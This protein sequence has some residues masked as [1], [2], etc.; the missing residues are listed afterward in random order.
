MDVSRLRVG[1]EDFLVS[2]MI[3]RCPKS[4]M[5]RELTKNAIEAASCADAG[6]RLVEFSPL[7]VNGVRKLAIWN[8]GPGMNADEL[9]QICDI[10]SSIGKQNALDQNF[11]MGAKVAS[12][13]SNTVG[14]RYRSCKNAK[15]HQVIMGKID[16]V[17]GRLRQVGS[18]GGEAVVLDVTGQAVA[19][20]RTLAYDWTEVVLLGND[21]SQDTVTDPYHGNPAMPAHWIA[22]E[23]YTRFFILPP[24]VSIILK[25]GCNI[26]GGD[27]EFAAMAARL[28]QFTK[29]EAVRIESGIILHY[30]YDALDPDRS[31]RFV[32]ERNSLQ[33]ARATSALI[34]RGE[35]YDL[36]PMWAWLHEAPIFGV[37]F[38]ARNI[39][40][41]IELP[42]GFPILPDGY[43][44]FLR[45]KDNLQ[46]NV[47]AR[48]FASQVLQYRPSWLVDLLRD[49]APDGQHNEHLRGE[50]NQLF[51]SLGMRRRWWPPGGGPAS[52]AGEEV[53]YEVAPQVMPLR[54]VTDIYER[55][56]GDKAARF[57][58]E[59]HQL[60]VNTHYSSFVSFRK[61]LEQEFATFSDLE[62]MR[63][64][65]LIVCEQILI[66]AICRKLVFA[67][68]KRGVWPKWEVDQAF[69]MMSLT[70]AADDR[71]GLFE[72]ARSRIANQL[73]S[74][75][76]V[77]DPKLKQ[78]H[79][80]LA[81]AI[82][83]VLSLASPDNQADRRLELSLRLL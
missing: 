1:N 34:Y 2:S 61:E 47:I 81:V 49:F 78:A 55:G 37:P 44:Q 74:A 14:I 68:A 67:L 72:E 79:S 40:V 33:P 65:V 6:G 46:Q 82:R 41:Y 22:E 17:Y 77:V 36:R 54:D 43:R 23:L 31:G 75:S 64:T 7:V 8:T 16:G 39:S 11:G 38:G 35:L 48:D 10:A 24:D 19:E 53:E 18:D 5:L 20:G 60:F 56:M 70:L 69:S 12:L 50:M 29:Y 21:L 25:A 51:R 62:Q 26:G 73:D 15:V 9:F 83:D 42:D 4:M 30:F 32:S 28:P 52:E 45:Y 63:R 57:Y 27:R 58:Q 59:T 76:M 71:A 80:R 13:P 66:R 3:E